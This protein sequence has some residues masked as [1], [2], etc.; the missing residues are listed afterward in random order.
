MPIS[1]EILQ[2]INL[3]NFIVLDLET[4][5]LDPAKDRIIEIGAIRYINGEEEEIFEE[6]INPQIP[7]PDFIT[8]L[9]G[10]S[11]DDVKNAPT[12]DERFGRLLE[13]IDDSLIL[14]HQVNFDASFIEYL[15]RKSEEDFTN[16]EKDT[17]RFKYMKNKRLD[18]LFLSRIFLPFLPRMNLGVV[19]AHFNIDL[20]NAHRALDDSRATGLIFFHLIEKAIAT[21]NQVLEK[22]MRLLYRN[23]NR[24]KYFFQPILD[25][26]IKNNIKVST[27]NITEDI[28][29][30]NQFYNIIGEGDYKLESVDE[31]VRIEPIDENDIVDSLAGNSRLTKVLENFENREQQQEM[32]KNIAQAFNNSEFLIVEAATGTG[33]SMAYLMPAI[34]W[35]VKNR[36]AR[37]RVII[38]TNTK[39]LQE[40]LFFKDIPSAFA[41][42][43][44]KF[45]AV[46]LKGK[47]NYLCLDK[48]K[49][50]LTDMNQRLSATERNRILP[51]MTWVEQTQTGDIAENAGFQINQNWGLWNKLIA[52]NNYCPGR[53]CKFYNEC[54]LIKARNNARAADVVIVN[55][56]LLF[57]D[58]VAENSILGEYNNLIIDEAHNIE[59]TA[60]EYLGVRFNWWSFRNVYH[61]LY[62]QEPKKTG[63]LV[64]LEYRLNKS[65]LDSNI[66]SMLQ[67]RITRLE[68]ESIGLKNIAQQFFAELN[69]G[70]KEKFKSNSSNNAETKLRYF[71][72]FKNFK[73]I[74]EIIDDT[75]SSLKG[76]IKKLSDLLEAFTDLKTESFEFQDQIHRE[77]ISIETDL[78]ALFNAFEFCIN[79]D[80]DKHVY[81]LEMPLREQR[82]DVTFNA[83]PLNV[84]E[85][86][87]M[88]L[89][90]RLN[91]AV[92]TSATLAVDNQFTYFMNR[93]GLNLLKHKAVNTLKL[94]SPFDLENQILLGVPDFL[95]DPRNERFT[96]QL[97]DMIKEIHDYHPTGMLTLFT[98]YSMLNM[99]YNQLKSHFEGKHVLLLAQGKSG[100]RTNIINQ[101][102]EYKESVLFGTDSFW[103][104]I[105]VPGGALEILL[106]TKLPFDVPTEPL[107][108][109][110]MEEIKKSGGNPFFE[111]SVPEAI[112]KFRQGFGRL[113][114]HKND[115]G[116]II[117]CDNRL[118]RMQYGKQFLNSLPV[119]AKIFND[120]DTMLSELKSWFSNTTKN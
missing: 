23:N 80:Q 24:V 75:R 17:Q 94:Q 120:K 91:A 96:D 30:V 107:I 102:R 47:S 40:Q 53:Q 4:T 16:W 69:A 14:G 33:K 79:A 35:A 52:E 13:F 86:L 87:K 84:A 34:E 39:N 48:W 7:I 61:N 20:E 113:I 64:Q 78:A 6:M 110:R 12:I 59:K 21:D 77:L 37:E 25:Y 81:W 108:A 66:I 57:S 29:F 88:N 112:I 97:Q 51:L 103:E 32:G 85:L 5:G 10:I 100:S 119:E 58:L 109:A 70:L 3:D 55:H 27:A 28:S 38:S 46:L 114:R 71:K 9:T 11:D 101:F 67:K 63:A 116:A 83:V 42:A 93:V 117:V 2:D 31:D 18:T 99:L 76:C 74:Q 22:I 15:L 98:S 95:D 26:K 62:E 82:I 104:G 54:Y 36:Q 1:K 44:K 8:K 90:D 92:F 73:D 89:Y 65:S 115:F 45:K 50:T 49:S 118:S 43:N 41:V 68:T 72:N 106:I 105:D 111:Y 60:A 19:A 56:S